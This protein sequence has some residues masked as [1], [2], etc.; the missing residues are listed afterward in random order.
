MVGPH[1]FP[2]RVPRWF[3]PRRHRICC[4]RRRTGCLGMSAEVG[5]NLV[6]FLG[7]ARTVQ[8]DSGVCYLLA[9]E[10]RRCECTKLTI[11]ATSKPLLYLCPSWTQNGYAG[12]QRS[13]LVSDQNYPSMYGGSR[14]KIYAAKS[15]WR[16]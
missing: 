4:R 2:D 12:L 8:D 1:H 15:W 9:R 14:C 11:L 6:V 7:D 13:P 3:R 10:C 5:E 16:C